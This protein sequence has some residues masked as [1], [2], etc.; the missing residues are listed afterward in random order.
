VN[1]Y[2]WEVTYT[3]T[4]KDMVKKDAAWLRR[5]RLDQISK[6][7]AKTFPNPVDLEN[8]VLLCEYELGLS[9]NTAMKYIDLVCRVKGWTVRDGK[10]YPPELEES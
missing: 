4:V 2:I 3:F 8:L 7:I 5:Q 6:I 9:E 10:I 1:A